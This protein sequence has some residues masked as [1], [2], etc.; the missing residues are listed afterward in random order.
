MKLP[1]PI[2]IN[3]LYKIEHISKFTRIARI[4]TLMLSFIFLIWFI[5]PIGFGI[6]NF[7][8][9]FGI[10]LCLFF[11]F[12]YGFRRTFLRIKHYFSQHGVLSVCWHCGKIAITFFLIYAI[13]I[14][15]FMMIVS[16]IPPAQN[17]TAIVLGCQV[18]GR[19]PS[20]ML[21]ERINAASD[22]MID[23]PA[24][25]LIASGG[26]G[27]GEDISEAECIITELEKDNIKRLRM[28]LEDNSSNTSEN[29]K[30]SIGI[31]DNYG[32]E[33]NV[34]IV[35]DF[36]HQLRARLILQKND[37]QGSIGAVNANTNILFAP[38]YIVR[39]WFAIVKELIF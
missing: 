37:Y 21:Q 18:R 39:E 10:F 28:Y 36:F 26:K 4:I 30:N 29:I 19:E 33:P 17:S 3:T 9:I 8:N 11:I 7:G 12:T 15:A 27:E 22:Y 32:L 34:A 16:F 25:R 6:L 35:T 2:D 5:I 14:T 23:N 24:A 1:E 38:T 20:L 31:I 13:V